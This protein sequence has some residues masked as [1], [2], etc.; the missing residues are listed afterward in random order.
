MTHYQKQGRFDRDQVSEKACSFILSSQLRRRWIACLKQL[1]LSSL[2]R[3]T[4]GSEGVVCLPRMLP[5]A[6]IATARA[7]QLVL[8][9]AIIYLEENSIDL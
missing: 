6:M 9:K 7:Y 2:I 8:E 1:S 4:H 3:E 5:A